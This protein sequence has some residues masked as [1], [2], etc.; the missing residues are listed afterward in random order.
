MPS[1]T[2]STDDYISVPNDKSIPEETFDN[3][4]EKTIDLNQYAEE[5]GQEIRELKKRCHTL[6]DE[7]LAMLIE[8]NKVCV[9]MFKQV[10]NVLVTEQVKRLNE[11]TEEINSGIAEGCNEP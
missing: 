10:F 9:A 6:S 1:S 3:D 8:Q 5:M 4:K 7:E 11:K 2:T